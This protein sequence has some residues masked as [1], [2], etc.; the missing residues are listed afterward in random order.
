M[1]LPTPKAPQNPVIFIDLDDLLVSPTYPPNPDSKI[2]QRDGD[3]YHYEERTHSK[4]L[5]ETMKKL[6]PVKI[7]TSSTRDHA[8]GINQTSKFLEDPDD[9]ICREDYLEEIYNAE[10]DR[11]WATTRFGICP[12]G[13]LIDHQKKDEEGV[14][15]KIKALGIEADQYIQAPPFFGSHYADPLNEAAIALLEMMVHLKLLD[16]ENKLKSK[17]ANQIKITT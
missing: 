16:M 1:S 11:S 3:Q 6:A 9:F 14:R 13:I 5:I 12:R 7:L 8:L 10:G 2:A 17:T 15:E 4:K